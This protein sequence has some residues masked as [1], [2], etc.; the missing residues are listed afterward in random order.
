MLELSLYDYIYIISNIFS[1]FIIFKFMCI[2]FDRT[3]VNKKIE[4]ISYIGYFILIS[5]IYLKFNEPIIT[6]ISNILMFFALSFNYRATI[7][8][9]SIAIILIYTIL[10]GVESIVFLLMRLLSSKFGNS[11]S[12]EGFLIISLISTKIISYVVVLIAGALRNIKTGFNISNLNWFAVFF[13]PLGT[14]FIIY[15][16]ISDSIYSEENVLISVI[17]LFSIN[18][19]VFYLYDELANEYREKIESELLRRQNNYYLKQFEVMEKS[20]EN[21]KM[22]LHDIG[23]HIVVLQALIENNDKEKA[24]DYIKKLT[25]SFEYKYEYAKTG[26][27]DVDSILN[28]KIQE[29]KDRGI[30]VDLKLKIPEYMNISSFDIS[31]ILGN[32]LDNAIEATS[33]LES[34]RKID[35]DLDFD[36]NVLFIS[37]SNTFDGKVIYENNKFQ[38]RHKDKENRGIGLDNVQKVVNKYMGEMEIYHTENTF[39][40]DIMMYNI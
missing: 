33:M 4:F 24:L 5:I 6:M 26:N 21:I 15:T 12:T 22:L 18:I 25:D 11:I 34:N 40:V 27:I 14:L 20:Q 8:I 17:I 2:F 28:Y 19:L 36:R 10:M 29:A 30:D 38:T 9:R 3:D 1:T 31:I 13:I 35:I 37:I 16:I 7:K 39:Y 32:L 23:N